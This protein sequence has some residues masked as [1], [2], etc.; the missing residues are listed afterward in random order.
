MR[1]TD[2]DLP[3]TLEEHLRQENQQLR[4]E[5]EALRRDSGHTEAQRNIW[6]PSATAIWAITLGVLV[7][8]VIA[9]F[10]GYIPLQ[11]RRAVIA[12]DPD[13]IVLSPGPCTP[14]EAGICLGLIAEASAKIPIL[15]VCLGHQAIGQVFGGKVVRAPVPISPSPTTSRRR[16]RA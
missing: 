6:Q 5:L 16:W 11:N 7:L 9:F 13:A 1:H 12:A 8:L 3:D 2:S 10:A 14:K 15:G 4:V